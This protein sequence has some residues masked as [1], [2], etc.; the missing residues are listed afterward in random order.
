M[1]TDALSHVAARNV[2]VFRT[3][4][5]R[6]H[7]HKYAT[8]QSKALA[9]HWHSRQSLKAAMRVLRE[10]RNSVAVVHAVTGVWRGV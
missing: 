9:G 10:T 2:T 1:V 7:P 8:T 4:S 5:G 3:V 6:L